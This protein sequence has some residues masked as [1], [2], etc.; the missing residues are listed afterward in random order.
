MSGVGSKRGRP[1]EDP[2]ESPTENL[3]KRAKL[4]LKEIGVENPTPEALHRSRSLLKTYE[5]IRL[6][7]EPEHNNDNGVG[8][9][10]GT[11][12]RRKLTVDHFK[13]ALKQ[14]YY[15]KGKEAAVVQMVEKHFLERTEEDIFQNNQESHQKP[16][17]YITEGSFMDFVLPALDLEAVKNQEQFVQLKRLET[18]QKFLIR[19]TLDFFSVPERPC[20][21]SSTSWRCCLSHVIP[22]LL[23]TWA[24]APIFNFLLYPF[25]LVYHR[26]QNGDK[27][28]EAAISPTFIYIPTDIS[29]EKSYESKLLHF[30]W[31]LNLYAFIAIS[32]MGLFLFITWFM[33]SVPEPLKTIRA[34][35]LYSPMVLYLVLAFMAIV[36]NGPE[37]QCLVDEQYEGKYNGMFERIKNFA[38][39]RVVRYSALL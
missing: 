19:D 24:E 11:D 28:N 39:S 3:T 1:A 6:L 16:E 5:N 17:P 33:H 34:V 23:M 31:W 26:K 15:S 7:Y 36:K 37:Q 30:L 20:N 12:E 32:G 38:K 18:E 14:S 29:A 27:A 13:D 4:V 22:R 8:H 25:Y 21:P 35:E 10:N 2:T 9:Q